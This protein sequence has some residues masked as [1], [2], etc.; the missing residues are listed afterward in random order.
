MQI[1]ETIL[2]TG[3]SGFIG[4]YLSSKLK[5]E[6]YRVIWMGRE[7]KEDA[8]FPVYKWDYK[9]G[10]IEE[11]AVT[12]ARYI[13]HLAGAGIGDRRWN[14]QRKTEIIESRVKTTAMLLKTWL[15]YK[16]PLN[17]FISASAVGIYDQDPSAP[18]ATEDDFIAGNF[19][20]SVCHAWEHEAGRFQKTGVR[21]VILRTGIVLGHNGGMLKKLET[22][23]RWGLG[24]YPGS[25]KQ[26]IPWIHIE[27]LSTIYLEA[28][29]NNALSGAFNAVAPEPVCLAPMIKLLAG[30]LH[31]PLIL[32]PVPASII[33]L[34]T[35][36]MSTLLLDGR[37]ISAQKIQD[38]GYK[39]RFPKIEEAFADLIIAKK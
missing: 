37:I 5:N 2:I 29:K 23:V 19:T 32:P 22:P 26:W 38:A 36:E 10:F 28:I 18:P 33:R 7:K 11:E 27:D 24:T 31:K 4:R 21:T 15:K 16:T 30:M 25:G 12:Q 1:Q 14:T 9:T 17:A 8:E 34:F 35:G 39:F 13:I 3:G 6:G 20:G